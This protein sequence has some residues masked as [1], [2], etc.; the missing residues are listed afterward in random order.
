MGKHVRGH[1]TETSLPEGGKG[2]GLNHESREINEVFHDPR[3]FFY[4]FIF[5]VKS[6]QDEMIIVL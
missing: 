4:G 3:K 2:G 1:T 6:V 5:H